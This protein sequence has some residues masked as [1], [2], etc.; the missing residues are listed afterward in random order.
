MECYGILSC[1]IV[2]LMLDRVSTISAVHDQWNDD[3]I[4]SLLLGPLKASEVQSS[5]YRMILNDR[6]LDDYS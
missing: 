2:K 4:C 1:Y 3:G 6:R 5:S